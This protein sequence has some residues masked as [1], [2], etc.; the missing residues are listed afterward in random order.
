LEKKG[1]KLDFLCKEKLCE[2]L[3]DLKNTPV[4]L[5]SQLGKTVRYGIAFHH[6]G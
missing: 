3:N 4:G 2:V 1:E 5:D 6:A